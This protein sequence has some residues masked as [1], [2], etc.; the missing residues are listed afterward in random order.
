MSVIL[1]K[2]E[3]VGLKALVKNEICAAKDCTGLP[4]KN[5]KYCAEC[6]PKRKNLSLILFRRR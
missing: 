2:W 4:A 3:L 5:E 1:N 6:R